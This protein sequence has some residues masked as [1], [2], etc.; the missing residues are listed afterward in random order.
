LN[1]DSARYHVTLFGDLV[2]VVFLK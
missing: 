1:F 2:I